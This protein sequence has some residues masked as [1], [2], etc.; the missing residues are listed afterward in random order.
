MGKYLRQWG[1]SLR[2]PDKRAVGQEPEAVARWHLRR[3]TRLLHPGRETHEFLINMRDFG[4]KDL[5]RKAEADTLVVRYGFET[6][7]GH[8]TGR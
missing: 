3:P 5:L 7:E 4:L 8:S 2:R 6:N 1:L